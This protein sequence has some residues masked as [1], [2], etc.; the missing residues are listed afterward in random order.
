LFLSERITEMEM[1]RNLRKRRSSHRNPA[2]GEVP[3][4]NTITGF[5]ECSKKGPS[6][7][8]LGK[9]QE[10]VERMRCRYLWPTKGQRQLTLVVELG[11]AER[12]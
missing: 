5:M 4:P 11:K 7:T 3:R 1:E 12:S 2:Q 6:M 10:A 9:T 8:A